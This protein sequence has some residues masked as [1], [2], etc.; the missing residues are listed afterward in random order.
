ME[1]AIECT[2][3]NEDSNTIALEYKEF[4]DF[5]PINYSDQLFC[6]DEGKLHD[7]FT[8]INSFEEQISNFLHFY[9]LYEV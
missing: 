9:Y 3:G 2:N 1:R 6:W 4:L 5:R 7:A 8:R